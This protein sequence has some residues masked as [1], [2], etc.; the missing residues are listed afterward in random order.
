MSGSTGMPRSLRMRSPSGV[1]G[2]LA[3][4]ATHLHCRLAAFPALMTPPTAAGT[5]T[6]QGVYSTSSTCITDPPGNPDSS[7]FAATCSL[8]ALMSRPS[9]LKTALSASLTATT[10]PPASVMSCAAH[11]PTFPKP[12]NTK[13]CPSTPLPE[14]AFSISRM[15]NMTPR[16]VAASLPSDPCMNT[17]LPVT[18][19]G[20]KPSYLLYSSKNQAMTRPSVF[21]SGAG[22]SSRGPMM[23]R[24]F[25]TNRLVSFSSSRSLSVLTSTQTPPFAPP[26]GMSSKAVFHVIREA[27]ERTSSMSTCGW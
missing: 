23:S 26:K 24:H 22:M 4:S 9:S 3:A 13:L 27:R 10:R 1:M 11:D 18:T 21:M 25:C 20:E 2:P 14:Y 19:P 16:P 5:R 6:S 7:R 12:W 15:P 17:G 8:S